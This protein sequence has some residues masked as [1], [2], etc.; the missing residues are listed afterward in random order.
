MEFAPFMRWVRKPKRSDSPQPYKVYKGKDSLNKL[1]ENLKVFPADTAQILEYWLDVSL[2]SSSS[3]KPAVEVNPGPELLK[4]DI[5][6][7]RSLAI[8]DIQCFACRMN[9]DYMDTFGEEALRDYGQAFR[10]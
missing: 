9:A 2:F 10:P 6:Y 1:K 5:A 7:Y 3:A 4:A 8:R